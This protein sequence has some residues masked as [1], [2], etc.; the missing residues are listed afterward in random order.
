MYGSVEHAVHGLLT[1]PVFDTGRIL[2]HIRAKA[3]T[4]LKRK[5]HRERSMKRFPN[6]IIM[7]SPN[8]VGTSF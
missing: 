3:L 4:I 6:Q 8:F 1:V 2:R 7:F 5:K